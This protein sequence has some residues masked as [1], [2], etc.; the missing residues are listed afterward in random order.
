LVEGQL[1]FK[2]GGEIDE[3]WVVAPSH[4]EVTVDSS[5]KGPKVSIIMPTYRRSHTLFRTVQSICAQTYSN[6]ELII[7]DNEGKAEY[8]FHDPRI[9]V[10]VH[11]EW[12]SASYARNKGVTYARGDFVC[13]FD[14]DDYMFPNYLETFVNAFEENPGAKLVRCGM[15]VTAGKI[16]FSYATPEC[17]LRREFATPSWPNSGA[18]DQLYFK[19]I[20]AS[21]GWSDASGEIITLNEPLCRANCDPRGG[22]RSGR[23]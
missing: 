17:C 10:R 22:L 9:T 12:T 15:I 23:L 20:V 5:H 16:N 7:V 8:R 2:N 11:P 14:D 21:H 13:F 6:W 18:H 3:V 19:T 4:G 1:R